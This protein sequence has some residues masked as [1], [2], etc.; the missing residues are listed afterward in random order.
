MQ[1]NKK[2]AVSGGVDEH[3]RKPKNPLH[4]NQENSMTE[5]KIAVLFP[6]IG[7]TCD[8]PLLYYT[9]K[10]AAGM[11]YEIVR[12]S[13]GNFPSGAKGNRE[14]MQRCFE[15]ALE[16]TREL[17]RE[18]DWAAYDEILF[19]SKSI[20]TAV[21]SAYAKEKGLKVRSILYTPLA[22]TFLFA[23]ADAIAF[24]GTADPWAGDEA[25]T[26]GCAGLGIP[27]YIT[28]GANHS[29]ETGDVIADVTELGKIMKTVCAYLKRQAE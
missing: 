19:V 4:R 28:E 27:L 24:H 11:G 17:L 1:Y 15:I 2:K 8:R 3:R 13:Y 18:A 5:K 23:D 7:Y 10:L 14:K 9:G 20:G 25:V 16:Q 21:A 12:V 26:E 29:L 6:G 22:E